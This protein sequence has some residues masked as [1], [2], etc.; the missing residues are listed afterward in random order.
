MLILRT[1]YYSSFQGVTYTMQT[2]QWEILEYPPGKNAKIPPKIP[3]ILPPFASIWL[4]AASSYNACATSSYVQSSSNPTTRYQTCLQHIKVILYLGLRS[5][6]YIKYGSEPLLLI[7][8]ALRVNTFYKVWKLPILFE[9]LTFHESTILQ[10]WR[11]CP[12][13]QI[14]QQTNLYHFNQ[15]FSLWALFY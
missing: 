3:P 14:I 7:I 2:S 9:Y 10:S 8:Y 15:Y 12:D 4:T 6:I 11:F 1:K 5:Q 13:C